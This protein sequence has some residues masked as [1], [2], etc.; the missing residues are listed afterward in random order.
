MTATDYKRVYDKLM[1]YGHCNAVANDMVLELL[2]E[3]AATISGQVVKQE[4]IGFLNTSECLANAAFL[5]VDLAMS[6]IPKVESGTRERR[7]LSCIA[8]LA[9]DLRSKFAEDSRNERPND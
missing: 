3:E 8:S 9:Q 1:Q 7:E 6:M 4:E 5:I 2:M